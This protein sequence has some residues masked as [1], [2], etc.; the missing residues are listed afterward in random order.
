MHF[1]FCM[2]YSRGGPNCRNPFK[3][4]KE[5]ASDDDSDDCT[6]ADGDIDLMME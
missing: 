3:I 2:S 1:L 6:E 5:K 4:Y